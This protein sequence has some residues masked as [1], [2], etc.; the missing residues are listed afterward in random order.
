MCNITLIKGIKS[1]NILLK[2]HNYLLKSYIFNGHLPSLLTQPY[3]LIHPVGLPV[4]TADQNIEPCFWF[5]LSCDSGL[6]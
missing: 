6:Y 1:S 3:L 2:N 5:R 4:C